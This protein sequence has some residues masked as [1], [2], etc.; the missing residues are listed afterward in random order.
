MDVY[1]FTQGSGPLLVSMP[2]VG[3]HV[4]PELSARMTAIARTVPD[5]DWHVDRLYDFLGSL[6]ATVLA[7]TH[8]RY[9]IDLNR[10]PDD[11]SLYPGSS[12]TGL[13]PVDR[14]DDGPVYEPGREPDKSEVAQR[15]A[16]YWQPYHDAITAALS[17]IHAQYG[18]ALL[19]EAHSIRSV[20]PRFFE[21][22]LPDINLGTSSG[23][24][25]DPELAAL[26]VECA[27]EALD[28]TSV[29]NGRFKGGYITRRY[30]APRDHI[31]AV[32]LELTQCSY[33]NE[34]PPFDFDEAKAG[35][36]R[37]A[38]QAIVETMLRWG[39]G[40]YGR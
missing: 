25:A 19:F 1:R 6:D 20:V 26:L 17:Q 30:G 37:P 10:P 34:E 21:G 31:H 13:C 40:R 33:M 24:S 39:K 36:V 23:A 18:Y 28:Y 2:H 35:R 7:A 22:R 38:L 3:T 12:V 15:R 32:Q 4:P 11:A 27:G 5:T 29:L 16:T 14:F 9:V 8:S